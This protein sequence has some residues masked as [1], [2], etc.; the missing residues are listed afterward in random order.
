MEELRWDIPGKLTHLIIHN[1][2]TYQVKF[3]NETVQVF[4]NG[5]M[6]IEEDLSEDFLPRHRDP[7]IAMEAQL[8]NWAQNVL[9]TFLQPCGKCKQVKL[10]FPPEL[11]APSIQHTLEQQGIQFICPSCIE[12]TLQ[13][14]QE[15]SKG[16]KEAFFRGD[17]RIMGGSQE[18]VQRLVQSAAILSIRRYIQ[19][20]GKGWHLGMMKFSQHRFYLVALK[21]TSDNEMESFLLLTQDDKG[22]IASLPPATGLPALGFQEG[23]EI[24]FMAIG[25]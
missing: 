11:T 9:K 18:E 4:E 12:V 15:H 21:I 20:L 7:S 24:E 19:T 6:I 16:K 25:D 5:E 10:S 22:I 3:E 14:T 17:I 13:E 23:E 2:N 8:L 1:S